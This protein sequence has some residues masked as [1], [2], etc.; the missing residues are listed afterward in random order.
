MRSKSAGGLKVKAL[1]QTPRGCRFK[2]CLVLKLFLLSKIALE[3]M[4]DYLC[5]IWI[6]FVYCA[7]DKF[8]EFGNLE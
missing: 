8:C 5:I 3:K 1:G 2:S 7:L 6:L 4:F